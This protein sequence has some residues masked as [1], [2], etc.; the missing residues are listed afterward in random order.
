MLYRNSDLSEQTVFGTTWIHN[1][2]IALSLE[3]GAWLTS[4]NSK[5]S[6]DQLRSHC[7]GSS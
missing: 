1:L 7:A 2:Y 5:Q 6:F 3:V 4:D